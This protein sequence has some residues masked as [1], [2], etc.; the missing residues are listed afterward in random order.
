MSLSR[1]ISTLGEIATAFGENGSFPED[2]EEAF[3][4]RVAD[5]VDMLHGEMCDLSR[6]ES[7]IEQQF[8]VTW[9]NE[10]DNLIGM[11]GITPQRKYAISGKNYRVDFSVV[12]HLYNKSSRVVVECDGHAFHEKTKEQ[13]KRDKK[14][15]RAFQSIGIPI[16]HFTGSE[17]FNK[18]QECVDEVTDFLIDNLKESSSG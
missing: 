9:K 5:K 15:D 17:I 4:E 2:V 3:L 8:Y 6:C 7:P 18:D 10:T 13:A 12:L 16:L 14:R 1:I 11:W